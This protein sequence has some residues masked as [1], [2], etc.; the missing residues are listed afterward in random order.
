VC[1]YAN[2]LDYIASKRKVNKDGIGQ[3]PCFLHMIKVLENTH[4]KVEPETCVML[5]VVIFRQA[6]R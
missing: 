1:K 2:T 4:E 6:A 5:R 3:L